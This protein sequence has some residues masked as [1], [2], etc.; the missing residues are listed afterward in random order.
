[1]VIRHFKMSLRFVVILSSNN[2]LRRILA[3]K[4]SCHTP[5]IQTKRCLQVPRRF[6]KNVTI[7]Q[8]NGLYEINLDSRKLKTPLGKVLQVPIEPLAI[9]VATEWDAQ[10][11]NISFQTMHM[12]GLCNTALD[13][14]TKKTKESLADYIVGFLESD[15][16]CYRQEEPMELAELQRNEWDPVLEWFCKR[17]DV[18]VNPTSCI[19]GLIVPQLS[20][21]VLTRHLL[22]YNFWSL[23]GMQY[24]VEAL[25]SII[26]TL[27]TVDRLLSTEKA[28]TL[29]QLELEFQIS[30]WG[31]VEWA[32]DIDRVDLNAR[33]AAAILFT[34]LNCQYSVL[35]HK[36]L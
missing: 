18:I 5:N 16:I 33:V 29:S 6:Y 10:E 23:T 19:D 7:A 21:D 12:T 17:Y 1:M 27:V 8:S 28:A 31:N 20:K 13:N 32:H 24:A 26:L 15:T 25:R 3:S 4:H 22:S 9:A 11:K 2:C 36:S 30:R 35:K 34:Q 14:P